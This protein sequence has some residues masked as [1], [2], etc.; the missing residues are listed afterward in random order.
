MHASLVA[1]KQIVQ[2]C[3]VEQVKEKTTVLSASAAR[4]AGRTWQYTEADVGEVRKPPVM[5]SG[6]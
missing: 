3:H 4:F 1:K 6:G 5:S 2:V